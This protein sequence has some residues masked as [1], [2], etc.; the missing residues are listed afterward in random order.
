MNK[1]DLL[2]FMQSATNDMAEEYKRIQKRSKEDPGTAGD[3][4][5]ENWATLLRNWLPPTFQIVTKGRI[6]NYR[7]DTSPQVDILILQPEYPKHLLDKKLYLAGGV[8][9]ALECKT[10]LR[11]EHLRDFFDRSI[12]IRELLPRRNGT[13]Y[14]ELHS[15]ILYGMACH[16]LDFYNKEVNP[17]EIVSKK[18]KALTDELINS[19]IA[20]PDFIC[21][22]DCSYWSVYKS[23]V[24]YPLF[25]DEGKDAVIE[26]E[27]RYCTAGYM[28]Y[29]SISESKEIPFTPVG[30][31]ITNL[32][33]K[34]SFEYLPLRSIAKHFYFSE[35]TNSG[36]GN[37]KI[38]TLD[39]FSEEVKN[40]LIAHPYDRKRRWDEWDM[41]F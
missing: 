8:L 1:N 37:S 12:K 32:L 40:R 26:M 24:N 14:K 31:L 10:T 22:A 30:S 41:C 27:D 2:D 34:L 20:M 25:Y 19:P 38:F 29:G 5:E 39:H 7:G 4:S 15:P 17:I 13:P 9:A 6:I 11:R 33:Y 28:N 3:Q 36:Q 18:L 21:V 35:L 23:A 16:S